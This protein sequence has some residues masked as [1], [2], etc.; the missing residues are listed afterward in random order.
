MAKSG[1]GLG[2]YMTKMII[3]ENMDGSIGVKN[4]DDGA[5]FT[6]LLNK[7]NM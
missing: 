4:V 2:L 5:L 1:T 6:I 3:E 7:S